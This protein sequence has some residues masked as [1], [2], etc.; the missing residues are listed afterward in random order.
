MH[1]GREHS[2]YHDVVW[3]LYLLLLWIIFQLGKERRW[4]ST[5]GLLVT[6]I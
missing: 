4:V 3:T 6:N 2:K 5:A 1:Y